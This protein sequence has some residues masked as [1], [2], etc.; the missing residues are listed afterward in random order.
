MNKVESNINIALFQS[1]FKSHLVEPDPVQVRVRGGS[2]IVKANVS[3]L[4][5]N[6]PQ[7]WLTSE[8]A[9]T[10]QNFVEATLIVI[11][12]RKVYVEEGFSPVVVL[13]GV[14]QHCDPFLRG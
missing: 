9:Y 7:V 5:K 6:G 1:R 8:E 10:S 12:Y 11:I 13:E 3:P 2:Q 4:V 14:R